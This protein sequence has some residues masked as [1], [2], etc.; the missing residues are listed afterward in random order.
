MKPFSLTA[1]ATNKLQLD[2]DSKTGTTQSSVT[3]KISPEHSG[4]AKIRVIYASTSSV[5]VTLTNLSTNVSKKIESSYIN[6]KSTI[7]FTYYAEKVN[8]QLSLEFKNGNK[9]TKYSIVG[10]LSKIESN[11]GANNDT[12]DDSDLI[13]MPD[14]RKGVLGF[15]DEMDSYK[16]SLNSENTLKINF[17]NLGPD[18]IN[19]KLYDTYKNLFKIETIANSPV[20]TN[21]EIPR[22]NGIYYLSIDPVYINGLGINYRIT[23]G[24]YVA[25]TALKFSKRELTLNEGS[26]KTMKASI[27]PSNATEKFSYKSS[28]NKIATV[29]SKGKIRAIKP[30]KVTITAYSDVSGIKSSLKLTVKAKAVSKVSL[31]VEKKTL[32]VGKTFQI[33][34]TASPSGVKTTYSYTSSNNKIAKIDNKGK[35]TAI[36]KGSCMITVTSKNG[37][38]ATCKVTVTSKTTPIVTPTPMLEPTPKPTKAPEQKIDVT[39]IKASSNMILLTVGDKKEIEYTILPS[40]A[41]DQTVTFSSADESIAKVDQKGVVTAVNAGTTYINGSTLNGETMMIIVIVTKM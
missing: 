9:D 35:I 21:I 5:F 31:N 12:L 24:D 25:L 7:E 15:G 16:I 27:T 17:L 23:L 19:L 39:S 41:T 13:N 40:D 20:A 36:G 18:P 30:G 33:K 14:Q 11:E 1:A 34:A 37:K 38:K 8:Y 28:N 26:T 32:E 22:A 4:T 10:K 6:G 2:G 29:D 3:Y